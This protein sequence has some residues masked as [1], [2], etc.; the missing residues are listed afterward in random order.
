[1]AIAWLVP[2]LAGCAGATPQVHLPAKPGA[3][4]ALIIAPAILTPRQQV[5]AAL[6]GYVTALG[7]ADKSGNTA[8]ARQLLR[9]YLA[10]SRIPGLVQAMSAIWAKGESFYG[11][12]VLHVSSVMIAAGRA[13]VHD[14]DDTS[15]MGLINV[16]TGQIVPG[17]PGVPRD[18]VVTRLDLVGGHWLVQF[19]LVEDVPCAP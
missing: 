9:P 8:A 7:Q 13:F 4:S 10:P 5:D 17:S 11:E 19:Q 1:M 14:C 12:D 16:A 6:S 15:S 3:R 18:N 2:A